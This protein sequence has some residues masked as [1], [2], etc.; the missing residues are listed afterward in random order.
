MKKSFSIGTILSITHQSLLTE[1]GE[2][3]AILNFMLDE[4]LFTHSLPRAGKVCAPILLSQHPQLSKWDEFSK[5]V[6][7]N[8]WQEKLALA[9][10]MFGESLEVEKAPDGAYIGK[11]PIEELADILNKKS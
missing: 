3:Y 7:T 2:V 6:D 11:N 5:D 10:S 4:N 1:M 9:K 8:N